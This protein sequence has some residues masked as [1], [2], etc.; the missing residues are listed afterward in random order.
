MTTVPPPPKQSHTLRTVLIVVGVALVVCCA[1]AIGG[2]YAI[3]RGVSAA[4]GPVRDTVN[5][6]LGDLEAGNT[7]SAYEYLCGP[8]RSQYPGAVFAEVVSRRPKLSSH[9]IIGVNVNNVNG[10]VS[11]SV[12]ARL[13]YADSSADL[14]V[15]HLAKEDGNW[16]ICGDPY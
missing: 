16:R 7:A 8:V 9:S 14:H 4:T 12:T 2:G 1:G 10:D 11:G 6:F 15:F 5:A 3:Y 13:R